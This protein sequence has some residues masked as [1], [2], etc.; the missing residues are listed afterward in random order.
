MGLCRMET[1]KITFDIIEQELP[2]L[3]LP[4]KI[5]I[6]PWEIIVDVPLFFET[7]MSVFRMIKDKPKK[8]KVR[9]IPHWDRLLK[10]YTTVKEY[11]KV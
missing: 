8:L 1:P 7:N 2:S 9:F 3:K 5:E 6:N 4:D 11:N 10:A